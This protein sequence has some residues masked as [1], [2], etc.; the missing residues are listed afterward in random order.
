MLWVIT[1]SCHHRR[2]EEGTSENEAAAE[3]EEEE[4][5]EER[6]GRGKV[7]SYHSSVYCSLR[8]TKPSMASQVVQW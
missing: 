6:R 5:E 2:Y 4:E 7:S 3:E 1:V 8:L